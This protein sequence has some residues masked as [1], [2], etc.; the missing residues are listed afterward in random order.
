MQLCPS[1]YSR[2]TTVGVLCG[3]RDGAD[4]NF[5][6]S[7]S[8]SSFSFCLCM[9]GNVTKGLFFF[10]IKSLRVLLLFQN[11]WI[12]IRVRTEDIE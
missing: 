7:S 2:C 11:K 12:N 10:C 4:S 9:Y 6:F 3:K 1:G 5:G 8:S